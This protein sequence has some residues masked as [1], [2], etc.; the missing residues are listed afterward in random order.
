MPWV[1]VDTD[2]NTGFPEASKQQNVTMI[3][4]YFRAQGWTD[5]AI[6]ALCG[7]MEIE[8]YLNPGQFELNKNY[9]PEFGFGLVQ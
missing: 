2:Q 5:N 3:A 6:A 1:A 4:N 7:N 8:S 9:N